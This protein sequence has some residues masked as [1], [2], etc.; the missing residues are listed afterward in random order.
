MRVGDLIQELC[1]LPRDYEIAVLTQHAQASAPEIV[2]VS[3]YAWEG[4]A[5]RGLIDPARAYLI[6]PKREMI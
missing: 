2:R 5:H 3:R 1:K 4:G 6:R